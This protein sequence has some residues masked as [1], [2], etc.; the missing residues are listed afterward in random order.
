MTK[1]SF[2][3]RLAQKLLGTSAKSFIPSLGSMPDGYGFDVDGRLKQ[4]ASKPEQ[5]SANLGWSYAANSAI[6]DQ[7]ASV[8]LKLW[9]KKADGDREEVKT[10][11]IL[12][13]LANPNLVHTGEQQRQ[14]HFTY[15]N[16][17]GEAYEVMLKNGEPFIPARGRLP[18]AFHVLPAHDVAFK[19][20]ETYTKS[21]ISYNNTNYPVLSCIR[22]LN[23]D[24]MNP[25]FGRSVISAAA[26]VIDTD[27]QMKEWNR[28]F[29]ANN[30]RPS[31]VF[32]TSNGESMDDE[33]YNRWKAQFQDEHTGTANA[34]K[35]LLIENGDVKFGM[36]SQTDLDFL[37]SRKFSKDEILAMFR[38]SPGILGMTENVN[39]S[40]MDAA[41]YLHAVINIVP[42]V[43]QYVRQLNAS[44]ISIYDPSLELDFENPVP[45]DVQAKLSAAEKGVNNW[46][47]IDEVRNMYGEKPLPDG[48]GEQLY[49]PATKAP[50]A[51]VADGT[52]TPQ[53]ATALSPADQAAADDATKSLDGVKKKN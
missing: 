50:L 35:P 49:I 44:L 46:M 38:V 14:L 51:N 6:A 8:E 20:G 31:L 23:P 7:A 40:N 18:D 9:R 4:Y 52:A 16:F 41:F 30:A 19:L 2:R 3:I 22:D 29:F 24:P 37:N 33:T 21:T 32:S 25:Y 1:A 10:H 28:R 42:R 5:L 17:V 48:L 27:D 39:R 26:A 12:D 53:P 15:M 43:R 36:L 13:L 47:T 11:E 45:E 34:F